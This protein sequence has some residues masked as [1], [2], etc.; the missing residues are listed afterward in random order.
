MNCR[1]ICRSWCRVP[2]RITISCPLRGEF[3]NSLEK[4]V[5]QAARTN[6]WALKDSPEETLKCHWESESFKVKV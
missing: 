3:W 4:W 1:R 5:L 6:R 2:S